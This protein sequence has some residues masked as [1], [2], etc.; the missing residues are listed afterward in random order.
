MGSELLQ[1]AGVISLILEGGDELGH[2]PEI[3][4]MVT[5]TNLGQPELSWPS[6]ACP[7]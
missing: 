2:F 7:M 4:I 3:C 1:S 5:L 6:L